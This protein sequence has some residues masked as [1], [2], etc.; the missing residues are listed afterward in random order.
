MADVSILVVV[1]DGHLHRSQRI[2]FLQGINSFRFIKVTLRSVTFTTTSGFR[3]EL[4]DTVSRVKSSLQQSPVV[5]L[6]QI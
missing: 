4:F 1:M 2:N 6:K 5:V 3:D